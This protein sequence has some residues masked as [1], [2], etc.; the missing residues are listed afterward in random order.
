M[1]CASDPIEGKSKSAGGAESKSAFDDTLEGLR[2]LGLVAIDGEK[3]LEGIGESWATG[4]APHCL[5]SSHRSG[6]TSAPEEPCSPSS[7]RCRGTVD[8]APKR[9]RAVRGMERTAPLNMLRQKAEIRVLKARAV[10][11]PG[12]TPA[13]RTNRGA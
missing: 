1:L 10:L 12:T 6:A 4:A 2:T 13:T 11:S 9:P 3:T 5:V 7:A 8:E